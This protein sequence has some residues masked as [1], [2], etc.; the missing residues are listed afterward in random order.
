MTR[1][2]ATEDDGSLLELIGF[3]QDSSVTATGELPA[4]MAGCSRC[5]MADLT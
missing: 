4:L 2:S 3:S 1:V 5:W